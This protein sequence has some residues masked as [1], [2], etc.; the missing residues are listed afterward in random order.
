MEAAVRRSV[1][2]MLVHAGLVRVTRERVDYA[3]VV[4][5]LAG[6]RMPGGPQHLPP[7]LVVDVRKKHGQAYVLRGLVRDQ[8]ARALE[9]PHLDVVRNLDID[10]VGEDPL[11]RVEGLGNMSGVLLVPDES[12]GVEIDVFFEFVTPRRGR[13]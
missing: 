13:I 1:V 7:G 5:R 2:P 8:V 4:F 12:R 6:N 10:L 3:F 9:Y 11:Q